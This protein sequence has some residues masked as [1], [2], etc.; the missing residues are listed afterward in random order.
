MEP[1]LVSADPEQWLDTHGDALFGYAMMRVQNQALAEDLVQ[2]AL[3]A[4]ITGLENFAG[5][6]SE[7]TWLI[8]ILKNKVVDHV[9]KASHE[10]TYGADVGEGDEWSGKFDATGHWVSAPANWG[11]PALVAQNDELKEAMMTCVQRLP[12]KLRMPFILR[13]IDGCE[14]DELMRVLNVSTA[15]NLWVML[16]RGSA[17][18]RTCLDA[19]W[20]GAA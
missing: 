2:E 6:S 8:G 14:T 15:N 19:L 13:E 20:N 16:S 5:K 11:D 4:G 18:V 17:R 7:R 3:L 1:S 9:R 12:E 10:Q